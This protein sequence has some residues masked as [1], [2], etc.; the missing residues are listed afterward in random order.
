[1]TIQ[2]L[3]TRGEIEASAPKHIKQSGVLIDNKFLIDLGEREYVKFN[4]EFILIT[5]F[6]PDH[7]FF[8][9]NGEKIKI[10]VPVFAPEALTGVSGITS[11]SLPFKKT[12]YLITPI[13]T[14]HS[15]KVKSQGYIIEKNR[16]RI[17]YSGDLITVRKKFHSR[18]GRLDLI[19]TEGSFIRR[20]GIV[21]RHTESKQLYGHAGIPD[22]IS[23]FQRFTNRI[24]FMHF[25]TWF[26]KDIHAGIAK[27]KSFEKQGL[28][29]E[30]A[31]DGKK[32]KV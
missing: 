11:T 12:N 9:R 15:I 3:G 14:V 20:G 21:R 6:H 16:K 17:F 23:L 28:N 7:A 22:L 26:M 24:I 1:M 2:I 32:Y 25:G 5:H 8:A 30:I 10:N 4:P 27:I 18:L 29:L 19:V 31:E 13:P